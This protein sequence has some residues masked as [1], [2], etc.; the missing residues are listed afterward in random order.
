MYQVMK[1]ID[2]K[3]NPNPLALYKHLKTKDKQNFYNK[4]LKGK[5]FDWV[6]MEE[7]HEASRSTEKRAGD[8]VDDKVPDCSP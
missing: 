5:T 4:Y 1:Y 6:Q 7:R 3:G 2:K 8:G